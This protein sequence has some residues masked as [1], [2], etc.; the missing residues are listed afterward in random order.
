MFSVAA[1]DIHVPLATTCA[2]AWISPGYCR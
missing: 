2:M 1:A